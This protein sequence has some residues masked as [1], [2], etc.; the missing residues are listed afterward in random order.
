[1]QFQGN[2]LYSEAKRM[3]GALNMSYAIEKLILQDLKKLNK[4]FT[5]KELETFIHKKAEIFTEKIR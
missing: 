5:E 1:M 4:S 3:C 2:I